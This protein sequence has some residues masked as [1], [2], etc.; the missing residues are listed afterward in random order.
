MISIIVPV[1]KGEKTLRR[2]IE[3]L[4]VQTDPELEIIIAVD[5]PPDASGVMADELAVTDNRIHVIHQEN[6]GVSVARNTGIAAANGEYLMFVDSDDYVEPDFC[7][8]MK[9]TLEKNATDLVVCGFHHWYFGKDVKKSP[10]HPG[11]YSVVQGREILELYEEQ[12]M[13]MP[14]NKIFRRD[15][16]SGEFPLGI[17]L[18]E[19]LIFNLE[20]LKKCSKVSVIPDLLYHYIQGESNV[21]L[22]TKRRSDRVEMALLIYKKV[23]EC[24]K[25]TLC[26][27]ETYGIPESKLLVEFLD[28]MEG[29]YFQKDL[30][31]A[32]KKTQMRIF[33][34]A[35]KIIPDGSMIRLYKMDYRI[36]YYF[37][38]RNRLTMMYILIMARG[39]LVT[40]YRK[41]EKKIR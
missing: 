1:Y 11:T 20:Y 40:L 24:V 19:D 41:L 36:L 6:Q 23:S 2:C 33:R 32:D 9:K 14:W 8:T 37:F 29:L 10:K 17:S 21:T 34:D 18:G 16:L 39:I 38:S 12:F 22:S 27:D 26:L 31:F 13:N 7:E 35:W 25:N 30:S 3:S 5:G 28:E 15:L 4:L